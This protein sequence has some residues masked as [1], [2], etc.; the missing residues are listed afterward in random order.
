MTAKELLDQLPGIAYEAHKITNEGLSKEREF[1]VTNFRHPNGDLVNI[2]IEE[3]AE[4]FWLSDFGNTFF[5]LTVDSIDLGNE[6]NMDIMRRMAIAH[7]AEIHEDEIRIKITPKNAAAEALN[8]CQAIS[9]IITA[10]YWAK[11]R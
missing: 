3:N 1:V 11:R 10:V 4:G 7:G 5:A 2:Y 8:L 6:E 9:Y